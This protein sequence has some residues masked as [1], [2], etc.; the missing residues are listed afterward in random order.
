[1]RPITQELARRRL[2]IQAQ[3][4]HHGG[5]QKEI[6]EKGNADSKTNGLRSEHLIPLVMD[7]D[8][9]ARK[10]RQITSGNSENR[11]IGSGRFNA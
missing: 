3:T 8:L 9:D 4:Y 6:G 10:V 2:S 1:M 5:E 11:H 7:A